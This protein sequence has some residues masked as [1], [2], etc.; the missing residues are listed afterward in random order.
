[1]ELQ[2]G[3]NFLLPEVKNL[4]LA[5]KQKNPASNTDV[6]SVSSASNS[7]SSITFLI[8]VLA[9]VRVLLLY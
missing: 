3:S 7:K 5:A 6:K 2:H 1:V 9:A 4:N 8:H